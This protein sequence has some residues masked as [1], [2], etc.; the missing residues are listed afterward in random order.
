MQSSAIGQLFIKQTGQVGGTKSYVKSWYLF[1]IFIYFLLSLSGNACRL[2]C[3]KLFSISYKCHSLITIMGGELV[4]W[5]SKIVLVLLLTL[6][7]CTF[8]YPERDSI[9]MFKTNFFRE[10][11]GIRFSYLTKTDINGY[12]IHEVREP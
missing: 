11:G 1:M 9:V 6:F 4:Q 8:H 7:K 2:R 5:D 10:K 12:K 3:L